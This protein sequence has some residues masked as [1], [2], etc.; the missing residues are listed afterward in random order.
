MGQT[1]LVEAVTVGQSNIWKNLDCFKKCLEA[2]CRCKTILDM[3]VISTSYLDGNITYKLYATYFQ[4][5]CKRLYWL[6]IQL[7]IEH[8]DLLFKFSDT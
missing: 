7:S 4:A 5:E 8:L 2:R 1:S 6:S 3:F